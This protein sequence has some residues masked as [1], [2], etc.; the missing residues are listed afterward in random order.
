VQIVPYRDG[1]YLVRGDFS[2]RDQNGDTIDV[3]RRTVALC[4]CGKSQIRPFCDGT[5]RLIRFR[6]P[7]SAEDPHDE[8]PSCGTS[9]ARHGTAASAGPSPD[10]AGRAP[11]LNGR[12]AA[13]ANAVHT[14]GTHADG[15][16][17]PT[18][19]TVRSVQEQLAAVQARLALHLQRPGTPETYLALR[20]AQPLV[21]AAWEMLATQTKRHRVDPHPGVDGSG[22]AVSLVGVPCYLFGDLPRLGKLDAEQ[23]TGDAAA[24]SRNAAA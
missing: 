12:P 8:D 13:A 20:A 1:P 11:G 22:L 10:G 7:S 6:A 23:G 2:L 21:T 3:S 4:R 24:P 15:S 5:H 14:N 16:A 17:A 18:Q 19:S 9:S